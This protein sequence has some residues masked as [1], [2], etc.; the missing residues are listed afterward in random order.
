MQLYLSRVAP[1]EQF[2]HPAADLSTSVEVSRSLRRGWLGKLRPSSERVGLRV[3]ATAYLVAMVVVPIATLV[4]EGFSAGTKH[5]IA[6]VTHPVA[7]AALW[8]SLKTGLFMA[9]V[10]AVMGTLIAYVLVRYRFPGRKLL[11]LLIDLPFAIP[12]LV[13]GMMIVTLLGPHAAL[14]K[15]FAAAG[16]RV[17]YA[18]P[19][20]TLALL[21]VTLPLV[22]RSVQP[23]LLELDIA[24]EEAAFTLG[25]G[26]WATFR[27]VTLPAIAPAILAGALQ[28]FARALGEFGSIV[29]VAGN[30]PR[31]TLTAAVYVFGEVE[32]GD[33]RSASAM[34]LLLVA[35]SF[36]VVLAL[37][38]LSRKKQPRG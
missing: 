32:S 11:D 12:T 30:L 3:I 25:A 29:V 4:R 36:L 22:V 13:T 1:S 10:N 35:I 19:A 14:G 5:I 8:L 9:L 34:S 23:V 26:E 17:V 6:A 2:G 16:V 15:L 33:L 21:F 7:L 27:R 37:D 24:E 31:K 20:I 18:A 28:S 38:L